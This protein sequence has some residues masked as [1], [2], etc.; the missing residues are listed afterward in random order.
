MKHLR[1]MI[2]LAASSA[3]VLVGVSAASPARA[4]Q[5]VGAARAPV[6]Y[7]Q[8]P[9]RLAFSPDGKSVAVA[10]CYRNVA[11]VFDTTTGRQ[12]H[13]LKGH[14]ALDPVEG[15]SFSAN[16]KLLLSRDFMTAR[17]WDA[18]TG[19]PLRTLGPTDER[20]WTTW[21]AAFSPN[22]KL[23]VTAN[24]GNL[25]GH[26]D[27]ARIWDAA[28]GRLLRTL[29]HA[30]VAGAAFSPNGKLIVTA[31]TFYGSAPPTVRT[32]RT[33]SGRRLHTWEGDYDSSASFSP[34]SSLLATGLEPV[35]V[36]RTTN[37]RLFRTVEGEDAI[38]SPDGKL[39]ATYEYR[40][41]A[42]D[43]V[44]RIW[45]ITSGRLLH[46]FKGEGVTFSPN[47]R[48]VLTRG[49][50]KVRIW[51]TFGGTL[52]RTLRSGDAGDAVFSADGELVATKWYE[53]RVHISRTTSGRTASVLQCGR[54]P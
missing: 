37:G 28:S 30:D 24:E 51:R 32:W 21:S 48:L 17:I 12:L 23:V 38:F 26:G 41:R 15:V 7:V 27:G 22:G 25:S 36:W 13:T 50:R 20:L 19:R 14:S 34:D 54:R 49:W 16:G 29:R 5:V 47:G 35:S 52:L 39:I 4:P 11:R 8:Y 53:N 10:G 6:P 33:A 2:V 3:A 45:R 31:S 18:V 42:R 46:T 9:G 40:G 1:P 43:G 44:T